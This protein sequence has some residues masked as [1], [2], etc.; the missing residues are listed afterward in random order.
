M[1]LFLPKIIE[2]GMSLVAGAFI[3]A[4]QAI[5]IWDVVKRKISPGLLSWFGWGLLMGTSLISQ[6]IDKGWQWN[7]TGL[8]CSAIGCIFI[9]ATAWVY[10][11][12]LMKKSDWSFLI[13]GLVCMI[14]Y[15]ISKDPWLTTGFAILA[16]F[17]VGIPTLRHA[18]INP[19]SQKTSAWTLGFIS[20]I[21]SLILCIGH[22]WLYALFP[23]YL[24]I[25]N[26]AMIALTHRKAASS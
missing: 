16:D 2:Q 18:W 12:Y 7:Q 5:L 11:N 21:F 9:F 22:S 3:I 19:A 4:A 25:Y 8:L 17:I 6:I 14:I 23:I 1:V 15:L 24:F 26:G 10:N 13:L 20:W